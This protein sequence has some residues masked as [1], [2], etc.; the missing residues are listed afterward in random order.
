MLLLSPKKNI[1]TDAS[2]IGTKY[3]TKF[4]GIKEAL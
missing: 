4:I 3:K 1:K 2:F